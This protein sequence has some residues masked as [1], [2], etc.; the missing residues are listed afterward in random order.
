MII[1]AVGSRWFDR[2]EERVFIQSWIGNRTR[3]DLTTKLMVLNRRDVRLLDEE[4]PVDENDAV[5]RLT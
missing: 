4:K 5:E 2:R 1:V 3:G